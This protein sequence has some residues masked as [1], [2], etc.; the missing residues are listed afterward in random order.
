MQ[1][2]VFLVCVVSSVKVSIV[3]SLLSRCFAVVFPFE[4]DCLYGILLCVL[5]M[6]LFMIT[7][8][9]LQTRVV[10]FVVVW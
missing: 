2:F 4:F 6:E 5:A 9:H 3:M 7:H 1:N 8:G 10:V